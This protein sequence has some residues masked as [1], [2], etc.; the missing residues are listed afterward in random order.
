MNDYWSEIFEYAN[1]KHLSILVFFYNLF[2]K[3]YFFR[4]MGM[5]ISASNWTT[6]LI[7]KNKKN[8][9]GELMGV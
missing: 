4:N 8:P 9:Y 1:I 3:I 2:N 5:G 6:E 7:K